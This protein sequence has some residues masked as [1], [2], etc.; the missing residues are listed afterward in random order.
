MRGGEV[1]CQVTKLIKDQAGHSIC[2]HLGSTAVS[3]GHGCTCWGRR[4]MFPSRCWRLCLLWEA[5]QGNPANKCVGVRHFFTPQ[6]QV[7]SEHARLERTL[8]Q[9]CKGRDS[10]EPSHGSQAWAAPAPRAPAL[11]RDEEMQASVASGSLA[12]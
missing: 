4:H 1:V 3:Q 8:Q 9:G 5:T 10:A 11:T 7:T 2:Q 6:E 12:A